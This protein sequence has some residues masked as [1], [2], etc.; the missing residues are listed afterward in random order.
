[1]IHISHRSL[2][3]VLVDIRQLEMLLAV[4]EHG[5]YL[6]AGNHLH[7]SHSAIHRQI[8][9]LEEEFSER[10][11]VKQGRRVRPSEP[12][13]L[14]IESARAIVQ[15]MAKAKK[16]IR[17]L[18]TME[19]G[20]LKIGTGTTTLTFFL[21]PVLEEFKLAYPK[22]EIRIVTNTGDHMIQKLAA[23]DLDLGL[24]NQGPKDSLPEKNIHYEPL[25]EEEYV[26]AVP[27]GHALSRK[28]TITWQELSGT[29]FILFPPGTR[30]RR[31]IDSHFRK[32]GVDP[33]VAM[34][35]ENEEAIQ[36]M[37]EINLVS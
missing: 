16:R 4:V 34:E 6:Q 25:F 27:R 3:G 1:V 32:A 28:R 24:V 19:T 20:Q 35:L 8:H 30:I 5:G 18:K 12:G 26:I 9:M 10:I 14:V 2:A 31:L 29:P 15:E 37:I 23:G 11:F 17:D 13:E 36:K 21:P 22:I 33:V 7:L